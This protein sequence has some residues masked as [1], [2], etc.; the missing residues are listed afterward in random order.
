ML[1]EYFTRMLDPVFRYDGTLDKFIGDAIMAVFGAPIPQ[2][3]DAE[4]AVK[5]ALEMR[6]A[7]NGTTWTERA[8]ASCR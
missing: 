8:G 5:A 7:S 4:N 2:E 1:N 6:R 3:N